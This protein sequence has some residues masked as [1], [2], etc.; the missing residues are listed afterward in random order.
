MQSLMHRDIVP[1]PGISS[2]LFL[3]EITYPI[4]L[5]AIAPVYFIFP[6]TGHFQG[7]GLKPLR[8]LAPASQV[9]I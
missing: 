7:L 9:V 5:I 1:F 3:S 8:S 2:L 4:P 6:A